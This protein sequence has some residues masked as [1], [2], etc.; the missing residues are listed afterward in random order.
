N[1]VVNPTDDEDGPGMPR[2]RPRNRAPVPV[3]RTA[4]LNSGTAAERSI[5]AH[6]YRADAERDL[7][8]LSIEAKDLPRPLDLTDHPHLTEAMPVE[9]L[10]SPF[11]EELGLR[12]NPA[13]N[14]GKAT[15]T[16]VRRDHANQPAMVQFEGEI[17][18]GNSGGPVVDSQGRLIGIAVMK[19]RGT[20]IGFA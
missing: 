4:V 6:L 12:R 17:H 3:T 13:V 8:I 10:G 5:A 7:A 16:R 9:L 14:I 2:F 18:P 15:V 19:L 1:H 11:G 20:R